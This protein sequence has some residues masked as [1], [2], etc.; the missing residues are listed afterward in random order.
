VTQTGT[1]QETDLLASLAEMAT[2]SDFLARTEDLS[3]ILLGL[4]DRARNVTGSDFAAIATFDDTGVMERF[5]QAGM[6]DSMVSRLGH[7]PVGRGLLGEFS[8]FDRPIRLAEVRSHPS[9]TGWPEGHPEMGPFVGCPIRVGAHPIGS[10]YV[11]RF[12]GAAEF[13]PQDEVALAVL[14]LQAAACVAQASARGKNARVSRLEER[15]RI[16]H[17]LHDGTIQSLYAL[18]LEVDGLANRPDFSPEVRAAFAGRVERINQIIR[19]IRN[20]I[21]LLEADAPPRQPEL[22][23]DLA[24]A[25]RQIVPDGIDVVVNIAASSLQELSATETEDLLYIAR[26]ALSNAVRHGEPSK[27]AVDVRATDVELGLTIQDNGVG[28]DQSV[29]PTGLGSVTMRTRAARLDGAIDII[30]IP[31]MGTTVRVSVPRRGQG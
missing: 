16:A 24:F 1:G 6:E 4:A 25:I 28:F 12:A 29:A 10:F 31:G 19:S 8:T 21:E 18:G 9:F 30:S 17:D 7:P 13:G 14:A 26:E 5:I 15:V 20:Y 2:T 22:A 23:R 27:V 11:A 3:A